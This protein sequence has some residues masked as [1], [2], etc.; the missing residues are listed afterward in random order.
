MCKI[1]RSRRRRPANFNPAF[2]QVALKPYRHHGPE[3]QIVIN[4]RTIQQ[5]SPPTQIREISTVTGET[6]GTYLSDPRYTVIF[7]V[8][9][10]RQE[11]GHASS[12]DLVAAG[13]P[14]PP[15]WS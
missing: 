4:T 3:R 6:I 13:I 7:K 11:Y 5:V 14:I 1:S 15:G 9:R 10:S 8:G 12:A 2:L